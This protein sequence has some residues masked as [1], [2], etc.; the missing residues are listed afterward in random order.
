MSSG[1][2]DDLAWSVTIDVPTHTIVAW[3]D[4]GRSEMVPMS[5][6]IILK[7][8][9]GMWWHPWVGRLRRDLIG[10]RGQAKRCLEWH[11]G[12]TLYWQWW[13]LFLQRPSHAGES[14]SW[15]RS[16]LKVGLEVGG[17]VVFASKVSPFFL[18]RVFIILDS[19][20]FGWTSL[21]CT[22][23]ERP[24]G[25]RVKTPSTR[26]KKLHVSGQVEIVKAS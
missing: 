13:D 4:P 15:K 19:G 18:P 12:D 24:Y 17:F 9:Y 6:F 14:E 26:G 2:I 7:R 5:M 11:L 10:H 21:W 16:L 8:L 1:V 22:S 3:A 23:T 25:H 20:S